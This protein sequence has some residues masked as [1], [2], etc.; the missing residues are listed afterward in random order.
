[1]STQHSSH[2][3]SG[4]PAVDQIKP[5]ITWD[6]GTAYDFFMSLEVLHDPVHY[7][8]RASWAAGVRSRLSPDERKLLEELHGFLWVPLHWI[9]TLPAPKDATSALW[10]LHQIPPADRPRLLLNFYELCDEPGAGD[11]LVKV[12][13]RRAWDQG[14]LEILKKCHVAKKH[15]KPGE[16]LTTF[17]DWLSRPDELGE[18]YLS[19]LQSYY[20][21][22]FAE[23]EKR[24][25]PALRNGLAHAQE[26]AGLQYVQVSLLFDLFIEQGK[27]TDQAAGLADLQAVL[28]D[29]G[30]GW[31]K[32]LDHHL[33]GL[34]HGQHQQ[35]FLPEPER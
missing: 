35:Q 24:I 11:T 33:V 18:L 4:L 28:H 26:L 3:D 32:V 12:I 5:N 25:A 19:A 34:P 14:D 1:M 29:P 20:Q 13:E 2:L 23:E 15:K 9:H 31:R 6:S 30:L 27:R 17:L 22:F 16:G 7:G 10:I 8:L 21:A